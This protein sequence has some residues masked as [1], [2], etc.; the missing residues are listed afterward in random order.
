M[1]KI[2]M[3][4]TALAAMGTIAM[5]GGDIAPIAV[6][7]EPVVDNSSFYLGLGY[8][9][10][11]TEV[12]ATN[13]V[14]YIG[15]SIDTDNIAL[16]AGYNINQYVAVEGRVNLG[17]DNEDYSDAGVD[18]VAL[19]VKPQYPVTP[20]FSVYGLLGYSWNTLYS[21]LTEDVD[22]DGFAYGIG[23]KY[24]V[25]EDVEIFADYTSVYSDTETY[26]LVDVDEDIYNVTVGA[27]YKF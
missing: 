20:E 16:Q 8:G 25:I 4:L 27:T 15:D 11:T 7:A 13:G 9:F 2:T 23:A 3:G 14:E 26:G 17:L 18:S 6:V 5:A 12:S 10:G 19:F 21:D 24:E 22:A 1:K